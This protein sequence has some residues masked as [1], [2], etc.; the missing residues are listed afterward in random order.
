MGVDGRRLTGQD[1]PM[2]SNDA[3]LKQVSIAAKESTLVA[4][5]DIDGNIPASGAFVVGL[6]AATP[7]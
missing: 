3:L 2:S 1:G 6:G 5:F 4:R 7:D